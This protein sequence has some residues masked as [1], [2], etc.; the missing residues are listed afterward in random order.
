MLRNLVLIFVHLQALILSAQDTAALA[1]VLDA[2]KTRTKIPGYAAGIYY[3]GEIIWTRATGSADLRTNRP[4]RRDTP[5]RL[6]SISKPLT[7]VGL[8]QLVDLGEILLTD[9]VR[10]HCPA[11]PAKPYPITVGNLLGHLGGIRHYKADDPTDANNSIR[12]PSV[13]E[14]LK[15]FSADPLMHEPGAKF[16]YSTYGYSL[17]GC[18]IENAADMPYE[19]W[20]ANKVFATVGMCNTAPDNNRG[21]SLRRAQGYRKSLAGEIEECAL[22]D[23]TAKIPGGGYVSTVE[24]L[25]RFSEGIY[26][27]KLLKSELIDLMWTSG[28]LKSGKVTGYGLG[29]SL[30][31][32]PEGD[33]EI[34]HTG[35]QQGTST[36]LY[37]RPEHQFAFVWL[38]NIEGLENRLPISRQLFR[39]ATTKVESAK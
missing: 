38:T 19:R 34:Y 28:K 13:I 31:R 39:L 18:A 32:A 15:K 11:F 30:S 1:R 14:A 4:V 20:M 35:G 26:R 5:F 2:E 9:D 17:A 8:L 12:F 36:I 21:I 25:L 22:T 37:L 16:L 23:N 10:K 29:W 24:D 27:Q 33:R 6:A 3:K 7:A